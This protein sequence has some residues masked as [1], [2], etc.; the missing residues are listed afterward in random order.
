MST[1]NVDVNREEIIKN[2]DVLYIQEGRRA[3]Q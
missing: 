1:P 3:I 2:N